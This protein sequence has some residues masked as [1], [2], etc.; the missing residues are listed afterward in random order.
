MKILMVIAKKDFQDEE[1]QI[2]HNY[3]ISKGIEVE[4]A[5]S[6]KGICVGMHGAEA[7]SDLKLE[8]VE[9]ENY[10][11]IVVVGGPGSKEFDED[12]EIESILIEAKE[13]G[14]ILAA[15]CRAPVILAKA[16]VIDK[17]KATVSS[18]EENIAILKK[19]KVEYIE[20]EVVMDK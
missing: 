9:T 16:G 7:E 15:I 19:F 3:F 8:D 4:V 5:S 10:G 12:Q 1:F 17:E 11:A 6:E 20:E 2:P 18:S 13:Q 14:K